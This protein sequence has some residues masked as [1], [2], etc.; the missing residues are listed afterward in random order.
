MQE[1][2]FVSSVSYIRFLDRLSGQQRVYITLIGLGDL[3]NTPRMNIRHLMCQTIVNTYNEDVDAFIIV[4]V[5][6]KITL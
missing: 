1:N 2:H 4:G 6:M 5:S 3:I